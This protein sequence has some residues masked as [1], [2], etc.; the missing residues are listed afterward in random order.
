M[1]PP[2]AEYNP[3]FARYI[4]LVPG[5]KVVPVLAEQVQTFRARFRDLPEERASFRYDANKWTVR[6]VIGHLI[7]TERVF[8]YRALWFAR[9]AATPLPPFEQDDF[10]ATAGHDLVPIAELVDEFCA[11]RESHI[12]MFRHLPKEAW[13]RVGTASNHPMSTRAAAF[14]MAGHLNYHAALLSERYGV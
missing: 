12:R 6:E 9:G 10:A 7:D 11:L 4:D 3:Y 13:T 14:I 2:A 5:D 8:G 1:R